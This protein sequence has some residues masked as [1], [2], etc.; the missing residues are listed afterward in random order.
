MFRSASLL[1]TLVRHNQNLVII[2][3]LSINKVC[4][5]ILLTYLDLSFREKHGP[6][7]T[8]FHRIRFWAALAALLQ[9]SYLMP[10]AL[11]LHPASRSFLDDPLGDP[12]SP[13]PVG[14]G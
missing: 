8:V 1:A 11:P 12:F 6:S 9:R 3:E 14:S 2:D 13:I 5:L 7:T 10:K 4:R